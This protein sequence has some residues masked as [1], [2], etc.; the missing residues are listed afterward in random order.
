MLPLGLLLV[1]AAGVV[2]A[3]VAANNTD[4][5]TVSAFGQSYDTTQAGLFL[6]GA[7][8][9]VVL[10]LGLSLMIAGARRRRVKGKRSRM[11]VRE[12]KAERE[13]LAE[14]NARLREQ[15]G[16]DDGV[17]HPEDPYPVEGRRASKHTV[18]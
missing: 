15:V 6:A 7:V 8:A 13:Q 12:V 10:M 4:A 9:G 3:V 17:V 1:I 11:H 2:G 16:S 5:T 18:L 14:E